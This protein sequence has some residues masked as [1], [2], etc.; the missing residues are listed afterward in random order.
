MTD[1]TI[2]LVFMLVLLG[3]IAVVATLGR[4]SARLKKLVLAALVLRLVGSIAYYVMFRT[5]YSTSDANAY[6]SIGRQYAEQIWQAD[7]SIFQAERWWG[8][9]F[10]RLLTGVVVAGIGGSPIATYLAFSLAAFAGLYAFGVAF[11]RAYP[12]I[13][14]ANYVRWIWLFPSL[15]FWPSA[16]GKDAILLLGLGLAVKGFVGTGRRV[17][18]HFLAVGLFCVF[19]VR[20]Q[21]AAVVTLSLVLAQWVAARE[22]GR[23]HGLLKAL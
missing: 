20:P 10:L 21:V 11:R 9:N 8:T 7:Y 23:L 13:P 19:A 4:M 22:D 3:A 5:L 16:V 6:L 1:D 17:Q 2:G 14:L 12:D 18:W 15:W